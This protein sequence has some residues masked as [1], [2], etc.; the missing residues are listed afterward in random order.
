MFSFPDLITFSDLFAIMESTQIWKEIGQF[1][2]YQKDWVYKC[3]MI[4][5]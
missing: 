5:V 4:N 3:E 2:P 1:Y